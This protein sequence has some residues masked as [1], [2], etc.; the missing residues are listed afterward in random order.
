MCSGR[1]PNFHT[2]RGIAGKLE[3]VG[4]ARSLS[5]DVKPFRSD[6]FAKIRLPHF[7]LTH[8]AFHACRPQFLFQP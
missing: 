2:G 3:V 7:F 6:K 1:S 4:K 5:P 8:R